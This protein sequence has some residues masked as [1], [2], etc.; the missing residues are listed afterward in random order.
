MTAAALVC[1]VALIGCGGASSEEPDL[2]PPAIARIQPVPDQ[3]NPR[4]LRRFRLLRADV[5]RD[6]VLSAQVELGKALF[7]EPRLSRDGVTS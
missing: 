2:G 5:S 6:G 1:A 3:V 7:F 4:L